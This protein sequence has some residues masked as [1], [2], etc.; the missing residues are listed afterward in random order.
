MPK[1]R[2]EAP[3]VGHK[4]TGGSAIRT[5][6]S[7]LKSAGAIGR[8][9]A[10]KKKAAFNQRRS[11]PGAGRPGAP[12]LPENPFE[13]KITRPK[14]DVLGRKVKGVVGKPMM[15]RRRAEELR[16]KT[17]GVEL[18]NKTR[19]GA[20]VD[21]RFGENDPTMSLEDKMME[22]FMRQKRKS[23][24]RQ[25]SIFNLEE[26]ELTHKGMS[27]SGLD[28]FDES[29]LQLVDSDDDGA[30]DKDTVK[31]LHFGGFEDVSADGRKKSKNEI[32]QEIISKSKFH[33]LERQKQNEEVGQLVEEVDKDLDSIK[34]LLGIGKRE[35]KGPVASEGNSQ[36]PTFRTPLPSQADGY[37]HFLSMLRHD[38]RAAPS[39]RLKSEEE[40]A[41]EEKEKLEALER[42]RQR[43]M[44]GLSDKDE[45]E[46]K[47]QKRR[48]PQGD[49][50]EDDFSIDPIDPTV[51]TGDDEDE[52]DE[53][54]DD[55][56]AHRSDDAKPL[57]Y[58]HDGVL[59]NKK[60]FMR[61][62][63]QRGKDGETNSETGS[64]GEDGGEDGDDEEDNDE[65]E[66]DEVQEGE[67]DNGEEES[68]ENSGE[69]VGDD[70]EGV[71]EDGDDVAEDGPEVEDVDGEIDLELPYTFPAPTT[72]K[73][74]NQ[75]LSPYSP[76]QQA[77][78]IHRIRVLHHVRLGGDNRAKL[79][80]LYTLLL[81]YCELVCRKGEATCIPILNELI[82]PLHELAVQFPSIAA[83]TYL[84]RVK[85][86]HAKIQRSDTKS[87]ALPWFADI[88]SLRQIARIFSVSDLEHLVG[89]PAELVMSECLSMCPIQNGRQA[90]SA[91][92]L[93][94]TFLEVKAL[95]KR[96][97]PEVIKTLHTLLSAFVGSTDTTSSGYDVAGVR[98]ANAATL[99]QAL[100]IT[101]FSAPPIELDLSQLL[102]KLTHD[103]E[104]KKVFETALLS[105][106]LALTTRTLRFYADL[107]SFHE[108]FAPFAPLL[109]AVPAEF[110]D[111]GGG[112]AAAATE[113]LQ[114]LLAS[115]RMKRRPLLLQKRKP[116]PI[117]SY[118]PKFYQGYSM[119]RRSYDRNREKV[120]EKKLEAELKK[121]RK[122]AIRELRKDGKFIGR[123]R[124]AT[125]QAEAA[126]YKKRMDVV[127]GNLANQEGAM[128]GYER[129]AGKRK[130]R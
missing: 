29:D 13:K 118:V 109:A 9:K 81:A 124:I 116:I 87:E 103:E 45:A 73:Q 127:M 57:T 58:S 44:L 61:A 4:K 101:D 12:V 21:R 67:D 129:E 26:E 41:A 119:D 113:L 8:P 3:T 62:K 17:L 88:A 79:E 117:A 2:P 54:G 120:A 47:K 14:H 99:A 91:L 112:E 25:S 111:G 34:A 1:R 83:N 37:D 82:K 36:Q 108:L 104:K 70:D 43:R 60:I 74:L 65:D 100:K 78:I 53:D 38:P 86:I 28:D 33:K 64:D 24:G 20:F 110:G 18:G 50:L 93:C 48:A 85:A 97:V 102:V 84:E 15:Q 121:E 31:N 90:L 69:E 92:A 22:R 126:A 6:K 130:R 59:L 42:E 49:D 115:A 51:P 72:F 96:F 66:E 75:L 94:E 30:I 52:S 107:A 46:A 76:S 7:A 11:G 80:K 55:G 23:S 105:R 39:N 98:S 68:G 71:D 89:S 95:S 19:A 5:I 63:P 106:T 122:G 10:S 123:E 114:T 40:I 32:M 27:L 16:R 35:K 128:R 77:T 56:N 125:K